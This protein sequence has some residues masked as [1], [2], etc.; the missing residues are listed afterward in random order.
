MP[1]LD[2]I[3]KK[4]FENNLNQY[5]DC[6]YANIHNKIYKFTPYKEKLVIKS[7]NKT[8]QISLPTIKDKLVLGVLKEVLLEIYD[9]I[10]Y[11]LVQVTIYELANK[12][13]LYDGFIKID[14]SDFYGSIDHNLLMGILHKKIR[15]DNIRKLIK[16]S[17]ENPTLSRGYSKKSIGLNKCGVPQGIPISNI[18]ASIYLKNLDQI[19]LEKDNIA[20]FRY[21]DDILILCNY[22]ELSTIKEEITLELK[23]KYL[24]EINKNKLKSGIVD[25]G[26]EYLG[27]NINKSD[28]R[29]RD[30][31]LKNFEKSLQSTFEEYQHLG[32]KNINLFIWDLNLKITGC[33][34][35]K[36]KYGWLFF[37]SQINDEFVLYH[38]DWLIKKYIKRYNIIIPDNSKFKIKR[39]VRTYNEIIKNLHNTQ[40]IPNFDK[41]T[42]NEMKNFLKEIHGMAIDGWEE[43]LIKDK[44]KHIVYKKS[45][46]LEK[47][48][49][50]F[51]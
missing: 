15:K 3:T 18:L 14:I 20:Y 28:I 22:S 42:L 43:E 16:D 12:I 5:I 4:Y 24:L 47:D 50:S 11:K 51:S 35:E 6:I 1:G 26:F 25:D 10:N 31:S 41:Y 37:F 2:C 45:R 40:Y 13:R 17:I 34:N 38:L 19:Y 29:V 36:N 33:I 27:Y 44:F 21:V 32:R 8:R 39:F 49:Q 46:K 48:I 7:K 30:I 23:D 9:E